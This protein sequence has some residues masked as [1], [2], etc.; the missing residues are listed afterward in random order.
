M[1]EHDRSAARGKMC[2]RKL[3]VFKHDSVLGNAPA[4]I[5]TDKIRV[6]KNEGVIA[7]RSFDDYTVTVDYSM[8]K[9]VQL[10]EMV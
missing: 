8:P 5:L 3:Y 1:F 4:H 10:I 9:G 6:N 7:P 2:L